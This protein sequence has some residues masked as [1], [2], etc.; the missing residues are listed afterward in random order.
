MILVG[1]LVL[2]ML[3]VLNAA[4]LTFF[5]MLFLGNVGVHLGFL[6]LL[7]GAIVIYLIKNNVITYN[8]GN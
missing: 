6:D 7:P 8:K 3:A 1:I 4:P 5:L 2:A